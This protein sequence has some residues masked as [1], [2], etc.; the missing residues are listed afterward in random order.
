M[1]QALKV[2]EGISN[3]DIRLKPKEYSTEVLNV[4]C[5]NLG[6][7]F[8]SIILVDGE[9]HGSVF[10]S[11][12]LP[13]SYPYLV[14]KV[15]VPVLSSPSGEAIKTGKIVVVN[16]IAADPRLGPWHGLLTALKIETIVWVPLFSKGKAF[17]TYNL[18]D[19]RKRDIS[20]G[21][22]N[23]LSHM[24]MLFS[25]AIMSNEYI[26]EIR[27]K[28]HELER[29]I[30]ERRAALEELR[31]ARDAA[32]NAGKAKD[33]FLTTMS[34]ELRTP[35][36]AIMGFT[37]ILLMDEKDP[38]TMETLNIIRESGEAL[39]HLIN[40][41][42]DFSEIE[43]G[44]FTLV[45][46]VFSLKEVITRVFNQYNEKAEN[47][48]LLMD[49]IVEPT[50]PVS[51]RG[52]EYRLQQVISNIVDNAVKFTNQGRVRLVC[53]YRDHTVVIRVSDTGIGI[54]HEKRES[55]FSIFSQADMSATRAHEGIGL[56]LTISSKL[57]EKMGGSISLES[58]PGNGSTVILK[59]PLP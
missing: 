26:D 50:V 58:T 44:H 2:F 47:K 14:H 24:S 11:Y 1:P 3:I 54:P 52:D 36:N 10:A 19:R 56:G 53:D 40:G 41:I 5:R 46:T 55:V 23:I 31:L 12:N 30:A 17:G 48:G 27:E 16:D 6:Y 33:E 29:E 57:I 8:G 4:I 43:T 9:G 13:E 28:T 45:E 51:I 25:M 21:E 34:H 22:K 35:M 32:E 7:H 15:K 39:L 38:G 42:L 59:L 20:R 49:F 37:E 18:Y